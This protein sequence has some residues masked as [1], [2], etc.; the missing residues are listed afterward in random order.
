MVFS[1]RKDDTFNPRLQHNL[2][3]R[4]TSNRRSVNEAVHVSDLISGS[5]RKAWFRRKYPD[6]D[7]INIDTTL[8]FLRGIASQLLKL[9]RVEVPIASK[10]GE[11]VGHVDAIIRDGNKDCI[12]EMKSTN[13]IAHFDLDHY[14]FREYLRQVLYYLV[15]SDL[16]KT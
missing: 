1:I 11:I 10:D 14:T 13:T 16:E 6:N 3:E 7:V 8:H 12:I 5:I 2:T 15:L 9:D 4:F